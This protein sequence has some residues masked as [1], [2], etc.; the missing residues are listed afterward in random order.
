MTD[1]R[2]KS[3]RARVGVTAEVNFASWDVFHLI[4]TINIS[5]GGMQI[6]LPQ[7]PKIGMKLTVQLTLPDKAVVELP[8]AVRHVTPISKPSTDPTQKASTRCMVG[9]E[10]ESVPEET[11][12]ML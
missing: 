12:R 11:T 9:V 10:F 3:P 7:E 8:A 2:R 1:D 4:Y 6:E 5:R